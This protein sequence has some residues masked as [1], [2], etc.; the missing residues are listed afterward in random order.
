ML[1]EQ[2]QKTQHSKNKIVNRPSRINKKLS[3]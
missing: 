2:T 3:F 1:K